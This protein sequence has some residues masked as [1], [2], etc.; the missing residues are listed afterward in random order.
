MSFEPQT[1]KVKVHVKQGCKVLFEQRMSILIGLGRKEVE[2]SK[3][4]ESPYAATARIRDDVCILQHCPTTSC[5]RRQCKINR[6]NCDSRV[7]METL[8]HEHSLIFKIYP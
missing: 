2:I 3:T 4:T 1:E 5:R 8:S 7:N 6:G